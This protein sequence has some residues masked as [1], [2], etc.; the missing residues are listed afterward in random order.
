MTVVKDQNRLSR[1]VADVPPLETFN[2]GQVDQVSG[3][4][5]VVEV[6]SFQTEIF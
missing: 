1:E 5:D 4:P 6:G 2:Q 3:L